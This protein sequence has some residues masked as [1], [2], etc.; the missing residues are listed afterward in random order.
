MFPYLATRHKQ[1]A[2]LSRNTQ[3]YS[4]SFLTWYLQHPGAEIARRVSWFAP[5]TYCSGTATKVQ[6]RNSISFRDLGNKVAWR[7]RRQQCAM[8]MDKSQCVM[9]QLMRRRWLTPRN[10]P[11]KGRRGEDRNERCRGCTPPLRTTTCGH[12]RISCPKTSKRCC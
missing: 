12:F 4:R 9:I 1:S 5:R 10:L 3:R 7:D 8:E 11:H 2:T 6:G